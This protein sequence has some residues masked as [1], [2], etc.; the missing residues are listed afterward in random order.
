MR[1]IPPLEITNARLTSTT[2]PEPGVGEAAFNIGTTYAAGDKV[3][4]GSPTA[5][6]TMTVA[7]PC[8]VTWT[9]HGQAD[10]SPVVLTTTGALPTGLT[11]GTRYFII[12]ST[13]DTFQLSAAPNGSAIV[14]TGT[15]SGT[16]TATTE[17]HRTYLSGEAGNVGNSP[18]RSPDKWTDI[19]P[20]N[21]WAMFDLLRNTATSAAS[22]LTVVITPGMRVNALGLVGLVAD[23]AEITVSVDGDPIYTKSLSLRTRIVG[24]WYEF[25]FAPFTTA[26]AFVLLDLPPVTSAVV[27]VTLTRAQ[28]DV[29]CGGLVL[30]SS[31]YLG[32]TLIE[33]V[34]DADNFSRINTNEYG[35]TELVPRRT[36]PRVSMRAVCTKADLIRGRQVRK[37]LA[38]APAL[39]LGLDDP[40]DG[41]FESVQVLGVYTAF[42]YNLDQHTHATLNLE[43][44]EV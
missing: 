19:G 42:S 11:A 2:A 32:E 10:G 29:S 14:T 37:D 13:A 31:V 7:S 35:D 9:A 3:I 1:V 8:V 39:W 20:T 43:V 6:V 15:Q 5:T 22:P 4:V 44:K 40:S 26:D 36:A 25:F 33:P 21:A 30:G 18:M 41:Y 24:S 38:A 23:A 12:N 27:T 17:V 28:G 16:H 34:D